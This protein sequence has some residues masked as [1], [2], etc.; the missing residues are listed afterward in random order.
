MIIKGTHIEA[1]FEGRVFFLISYVIFIHIEIE[2]N[3]KNI[4]MKWI[5]KLFIYIHT[6]RRR[7]KVHR[8]K[9]LIN[10]C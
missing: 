3:G 2:F 7:K 6:H 4:A 9:F 8:E 1:F 10:V 5:S